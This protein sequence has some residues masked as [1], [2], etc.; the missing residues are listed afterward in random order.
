MKRWLVMDLLLP[1]EFGEALSNFLMEKGATGI[2]E[3]DEDLKRKRLKAFFQKDGKEKKVLQ[4][5]RRYLESFTPLPRRGCGSSSKPPS[6]RNRDGVK[7]GR[8]FSSR[9]EYPDL[10]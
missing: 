3:I 7:T 8:G 6:F 2:E 4:D 10:W 5:L 9:S 1:G